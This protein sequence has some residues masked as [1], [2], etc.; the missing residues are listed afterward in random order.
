MYNIII[1]RVASESLDGF[2][3]SYRSV[4]FTLYMD[5]WIQ[6]EDLIL[7][8]YRKTSKEFKEDLLMKIQSKLF[9]EMVLWRRVTDNNTFSVI[10]QERSFLIIIDYSEDA[11]NKTRFIENIIF[12]KK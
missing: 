3:N 10:F 5:T 4:F 9:W 6:N 1:Q 11:Q 8:N 7:D 12:T 2:I